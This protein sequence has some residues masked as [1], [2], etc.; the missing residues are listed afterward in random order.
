M[1]RDSVMRIGCT[2]SGR[3]IHFHVQVQVHFHVHFGSLQ[4][5]MRHPNSHSNCSNRHHNTLHNPYSV[6][7]DI[8]STV[9][10]PQP[11]QNRDE[12]LDSNNI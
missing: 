10:Q 2:I 12:C 4:R 11:L 7:L 3:I 1:M 8:K 9:K 6:R 5:R